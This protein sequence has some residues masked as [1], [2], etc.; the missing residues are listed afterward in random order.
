MEQ[1]EGGTG[2]VRR[3]RRLM[4]TFMGAVAVYWVAL[5]VGALTPPVRLFLQL[6]RQWP[7]RVALGFSDQHGFG[8]TVDGHPV[9]QAHPTVLGVVAWMVGPPLLLGALWLLAT[10]RRAR[11]L[12]D[13]PAAGLAAGA[14]AAGAPAPERQRAPVERGG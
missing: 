14:P 6:R 11:S 1:P 7:G 5:T 2:E 13:Q 3:R 4:R 9:W 8:V 10:R 12:A